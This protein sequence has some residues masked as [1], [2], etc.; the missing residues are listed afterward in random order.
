MRNIELFLVLVISVISSD[1][2]SLSISD[3][4]ESNESYGSAYNEDDASSRL[5]SGKTIMLPTRTKTVPIWNRASGILPATVESPSPVTARLPDIVLDPTPPANV[6]DAKLSPEAISDKIEPV[7]E[8]DQAPDWLREAIEEMVQVVQREILPTKNEL[9]TAVGVISET[10]RTIPVTLVDGVGFVSVETEKPTTGS[11]ASTT[12]P[13]PV[14]VSSSTLWVTSEATQRPSSISTAEATK[15]KTTTTRT[16]RTTSKPIQINQQRDAITRTTLKVSPIH[17]IV[18]S[19]PTKKSTETTRTTSTTTL[20]TST[21]LLTTLNNKVI[22]STTKLQDDDYDY[23]VTTAPFV[24]PTTPS[25]VQWWESPP[26]YQFATLIAQEKEASEDKALAVPVEKTTTKRPSE[27]PPPPPNPLFNLQQ[28]VL[29]SLFSSNNRFPVWPSTPRR[30]VIVRAP[31]RSTTTTQ[32]PRTRPTQRPRPSSSP[33]RRRRPSVVPIRQRP[34]QHPNSV[35]SQFI[36][37]PQVLRP[38]FPVDSGVTDS[39]LTVEDP[40][41]ATETPENSTASFDIELI[42]QETLR[43]PFPPNFTLTDSTTSTTAATTST[44]AST[45][46]STTSTTTEQPPSS[47][48]PSNDT[49]TTYSY[50]LVNLWSYVNGQLSLV[51]QQLVPSTVLNGT[52]AADGAILTTSALSATLLEQL[53][54]LL[55]SA[56]STTTTSTSTTT[57]TKKPSRPYGGVGNPSLIGIIQTVDRNNT[58]YPSPTYGAPKPPS[59]T[60]GPPKAPSQTYGV[61]SLTYGL[62]KAPSS[63]YGVPQAPSTTYGAPPAPS[64]TYGVPPIPSSTYGAPPVPSSTYGAPPVAVRNATKTAS[65]IVPESVIYSPPLPSATMN[66]FPQD[67][68]KKKAPNRVGSNTNNLHLSSNLLIHGPLHTPPGAPAGSVGMDPGPTTSTTTTSTTSAPF[69]INANTNNLNRRPNPRPAKPTRRRPILAVKKPNRGPT[70]VNKKNTNKATS[71]AIR[72]SL[73][74]AGPTAFVQGGNPLGA[75]LPDFILEEL[76]QQVHSLPVDAISK[77]PTGFERRSG[78]ATSSETG[79]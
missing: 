21:S 25:T 39:P 7:I 58:Y 27:L 62:P 70:F 68:V 11:T 71:G 16:T 38:P 37:L 13:R 24:A 22:R 4:A 23:E 19:Q 53:A 1:C 33:T 35:F 69:F 59:Q 30:P 61:P 78:L 48:S 32:A 12:T 40:E 5:A 18:T 63:T 50:V 9:N 17:W 6:T 43:P 65:A 15:A 20:A 57:T 2:K 26:N 55:N 45:T 76:S 79:N 51:G 54:A 36:R 46:T 42:V 56:T 52:N 3:D 28:D 75:L 14:S 72:P 29:G 41:F 44:T 74:S 47:T 31:S 66:Q 10:E 34:A 8:I 77:A 60:Y 73:P 64:S 49:V 67:P